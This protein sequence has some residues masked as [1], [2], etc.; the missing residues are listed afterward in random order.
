MSRDQSLPSFSKNLNVMSGESLSNAEGANNTR[1]NQPTNLIITRDQA[2]ATYSV[3][4]NESSIQDI[5]QSQPKK[6]YRD[7]MP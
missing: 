5:G 3:Q 2:G 4:D 6:A 7:K 1:Q